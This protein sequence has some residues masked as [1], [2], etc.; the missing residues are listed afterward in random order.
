[1][2]SENATSPPPGKSKAMRWIL[3]I[4]FSVSVLSVLARLHFIQTRPLAG[5][6]DGQEPE[7][8]ILVTDLAFEQTPWKTHHFLPI[9]T[10]GASYNKFI[11]DHPG[12]ETADSLGNYFYTST[13][14]LT[15]V[16]PYFAMKAFGAGPSVFGL[17]CYNLCLQLAATV[18]LAGLVFL[19]ARRRGFESADCLMAS[20][21]TVVIYM[22]APECLKSHSINLWA[23][24]FYALLL[25]VQLICFL[26]YPRPLLLFL[27][28]FVSCLADWTPYLANL[29][30]IAI[31]LHAFWRNRD[32]RGL[33]S[34]TAIGLGCLLGGLCLIGWFSTVM[35]L[36]D[37][38]RD[39]MVRGSARGGMAPKIVLPMLY[40]NSFGLFTLIGLAVWAIR[41]RLRRTKSPP[42]SGAEAS[43]IANPF[44][45]I[46]TVW[47]VG[48]AENFLMA[49]HAAPYSYDR[50]KAVQL[51]A[52]FIAWG[53]LGRRRMASRIFASSVV[54]GLASVAVFVRIYDMPGGWSYVRTA[55]QQRLGEL[56]RATASTNGPAFLTGDVRG[57]EV[58]YS[59]R[60]LVMADSNAVIFA[61]HWCQQH[62]Y[63]EGTVYEVSGH[64]PQADP[65]E[66]PRTITISRV[67][68]N[69]SVEK[70][71]TVT[72]P[73]RAGDYHQPS[74]SNH[75]FRN[76]R[77]LHP[78]D[79]LKLLMWQ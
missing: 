5:R 10:L 67:H 64:F 79:I 21:M 69:G 17:R 35:S 59:Q 38:F 12:A 18:A 26:F 24:Q 45:V 57:A 76:W 51:L 30:M 48:L 39:L 78:I 52:L 65:A 3:L 11:D 34:A 46:F 41:W 72:L 58:Y 75:P 13:P 66:L 31:S 7:S 19:A 43:F 60:N 37:Y 42:A 70:L 61:Q 20:A 1:M 4:V 28:A 56:V 33:K 62:H 49:G 9:F 2:N 55:E 15:F 14:P 22:T 29:A 16:T 25:P 6:L 68:A 63:P 8:H 50:L 73:E 74:F 32:G 36:H 47:I 40:L 77:Q 44:A 54:A 71:Q 53:T 23:Q 27:L